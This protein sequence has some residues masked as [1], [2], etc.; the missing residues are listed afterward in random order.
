MN[1]VPV[2]FSRPTVMIWSS[3]LEPVP[4]ILNLF[5]PAALTAAMYSV[6]VL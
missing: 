5:G 4:P 6:A 3:C 2:A 1:L